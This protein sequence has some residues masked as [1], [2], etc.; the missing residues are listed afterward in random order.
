MQKQKI[1]Q[2]LLSTLNDFR[3]KAAWFSMPLVMANHHLM[4]LVVQ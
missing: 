4:V 3:V 1:L 2:Q